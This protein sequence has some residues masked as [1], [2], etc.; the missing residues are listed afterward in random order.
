MSIFISK[1]LDQHM[2]INV[3]YSCLMQNVNHW[4]IFKNKITFS[5]EQRTFFLINDKIPLATV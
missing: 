2:F 3:Y 5:Y 1:L 4:L